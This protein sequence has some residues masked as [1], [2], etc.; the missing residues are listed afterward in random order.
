M[1]HV[2]FVAVS[3]T[4]PNIGDI[5]AWLGAPPRMVRAYGDELRPVPLTT[6]VK[7]G[8]AAPGAGA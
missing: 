5:A 2:R 6:H 1:R 4:I 7:V 3:A 8:G